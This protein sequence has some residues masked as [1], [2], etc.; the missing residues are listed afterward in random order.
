[1]SWDAP[2]ILILLILLPLAAV[3]VTFRERNRYL[4]IR[5]VIRPEGIFLLSL[6]RVIIKRILFLLAAGFIL[7][8]LAGPRWGR[9]WQKIEKPGRDVVFLID[10]SASMLAEDIEPDRLSAAKR[11]VTF[12]TENIKAARIGLVFFA[13]TAFVQCP[14]TFDIRAVKLFLKEAWDKLIPL[15][16]SDFEKA[17]ETAAGAFPGSRRAAGGTIVF[18]TDGES[19]QG[20]A[21]NA[22]KK[23]KEMN[24]K[25]AVLVISTH[26]GA[27]IPVYGKDGSLKGYKK[28]SAGNTVISKPDEKLLRKIVSE[29]G[30]IYLNAGGGFSDAV[31]IVSFIDESEKFRRE[32]KAMASSEEQRYQYPLFIAIILIIIEFI[33]GT[34]VNLKNE[35][36]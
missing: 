14:V 28:D 26:A 35:D 15:P 24:I 13:G 1:M 4:N 16:G 30:G 17:L 31:K 8:A 6:R 2:F 18:V 21:E 11:K 36:V 10:T 3:A 7:V 32:D 9:K 19:L 33:I 20:D 5:K 27:P 12:M 34:R 22:L 23:L 25:V 29:T